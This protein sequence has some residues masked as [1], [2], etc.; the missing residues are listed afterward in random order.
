MPAD[1]VVA[2]LD[3]EMDGFVFL[4]QVV[5]SSVERVKFFQNG[6]LSRRQQ[7]SSLAI[8]QVLRLGILLRRLFWGS[9]PLIG[10]VVIR[11]RKGW[12]LTLRAGKSLGRVR[13]EPIL[14]IW[15]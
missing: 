11:H 13:I 1:D 5:G 15:A 3:Q 7:V 8:S 2:A 4:I 12:I 14:R 6:L 9:G 10:S